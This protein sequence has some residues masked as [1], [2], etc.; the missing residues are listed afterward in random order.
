MEVFWPSWANAIAIP[1]KGS[2]QEIMT[3]CNEGA[4]KYLEKQKKE[5]DNAK[6]VHS[7]QV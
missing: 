1:K 7:I 6:H 3:A 5:T 4:E 2:I